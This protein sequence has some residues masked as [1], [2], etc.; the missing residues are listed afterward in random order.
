LKRL[1]IA[2]VFAACVAVAQHAPQGTEHGK[3]AVKH[4]EGQAEAAMPNEIW[5]KWANFAILAAGL[6]FVIG[7]NAGPFFRARTEEIQKG[8]QDAAAVRAEAEA[9][10]SEIEKRIANL[11]AEVEALRQKSHE[12]ITRE[13]ERVS[14]ETA[15]Q[16]AKIQRQAEADIASAAKNATQELKAYSAELAIS[17]AARQIEQRMTQQSQEQLADAF[18]EDIRGKAAVN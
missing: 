11:N 6:G 13:G 18:V 14:A 1:A 17:M 10:A 4:G 8:I 7:K 5:W 3:A 2:A 9:R 15:T 12:E 16:I